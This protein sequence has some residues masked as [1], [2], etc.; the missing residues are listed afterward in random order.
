[1]NNLRKRKENFKETLKYPNSNITHLVIEVP[2][3]NCLMIFKIVVRALPGYVTLVL[4]G[5]VQNH[6]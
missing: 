1:M 5:H 2:N 4:Y 6:L 3:F